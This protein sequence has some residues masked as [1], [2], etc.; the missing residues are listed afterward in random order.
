MR[1][2]LQEYKLSNKVSNL[3]RE[4]LNFQHQGLHESCI[5]R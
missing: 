5:R 3:E 2:S 1:G 4:R